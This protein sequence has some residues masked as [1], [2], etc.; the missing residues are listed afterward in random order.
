ME[1]G[2]L[3]EAASIVYRVATA[4]V[5]NEDVA[6]E[7]LNSIVRL[8]ALNGS[9]KIRHAITEGAKQH[10]LES[11]QASL[12]S[13]NEHSSS[14]KKRGVYYTPQDVVDFVVA[15]SVATYYQLPFD[16][17]A[18]S[19][20]PSEV[21][22]SDFAYRFRVFDPTAGLSEFLLGALRCKILSLLK[23]GVAPKEV[24]IVDIVR[25]IHG[26]DIDTDSLAISR[27]RLY[28]EI[29][30][31]LGN[32]QANKT[33]AV[34]LESFTS[35]DFILGE[36]AEAPLFELVVG[37]PPYVED[38]QYGHVENR[39]G[40]VYCNV[41]SNASKL[42][43]PH[44]VIGFV[45]PLS[46]CSTPR[47][48]KIRS[49]LFERL[50]KQL[51]M[52]FADRPDSLFSRVHQKL[53]ILIA[54]GGT[55]HEVYTSNYRYWYK[56]ERETLFKNIPLTRNP[57]GTSR[58]IPKLGTRL[59]VSLLTKLTNLQ[60][61]TIYESSRLGSHVVCINRR[62]TF[63]MKAFRGSRNHPEFKEFYFE[64][65]DDAALLYCILNSSLFWWYWITVSDCWHVSR[66]LNSFKMPNSSLGIDFQSLA[67]LLEARLEATKKRV[68]TKQTEYEYKHVQC[69][70]ILNEINLAV[71]K[72]YGLTSRESEY[73]NQ[74]AIQ[75]RTGRKVTS[76]V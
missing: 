37:N 2:L 39:Y 47:M 53:C 25:T 16:R 66:S 9:M 43:A 27:L 69:L 38:K 3:V 8:S 20:I 14:R 60:T 30:L 75:Y 40:N 1:R 12:A 22:V 46:Y 33:V 61:P 35:L 4:G 44:G 21:P 18:H 74:F 52:S 11:L 36:Y 59:E 70:D 15:N 58:L 63:W 50:P 26:N 5:Q 56:D 7:V 64:S 6:N 76:N 68:N 32:E 71:N 31:L 13:L 28:L 62:E 54:T 48:Q 55:S 41:L 65:E 42:L 34:L 57:Y 49:E 29:T 73:V 19:S 72:I 67:D 10:S 23:S 45:V 17:Y 24:R 51:V